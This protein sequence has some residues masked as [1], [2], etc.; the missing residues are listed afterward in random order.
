M[1]PPTQSLTLVKKLPDA[2]RAPIETARNV[3]KG[4]GSRI[5]WRP[6]NLEEEDQFAVVLCR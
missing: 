6:L 5:H 3:S 4:V 2:P 1:T